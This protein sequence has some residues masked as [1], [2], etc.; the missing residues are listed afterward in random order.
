MSDALLGCQT[1]R[2]TSLEMVQP[3]FVGAFRG[4]GLP[5]AIRTDDGP[6]F[7]TKTLGGLSHLSICWIKSGIIPE[8]ILPGNAQQNGRH[9]QMHRTLKEEV[10]SPPQKTVRHQQTALD[11]FRMEFNHQRR[12]EPLGRRVLASAHVPSVRPYPLRLPEMRYSDEMQVRWVKS[13]GDNS[14]KDHHAIFPRHL[15][16][17]SSAC[18]KSP[19]TSEI[20]TLAPSDSHGWTHGTRD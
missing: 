10:I 2:P 11:D 7:A 8:R 20:S 16:A 15:L 4:H 14:W 12:H 6:P 18:D 19:R 13:Q 5:D 17:S 1:V 9:E 3:V